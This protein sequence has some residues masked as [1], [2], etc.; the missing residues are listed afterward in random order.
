MSTGRD[1]RSFDEFR[2]I[3]SAL[4]GPDGCPWDKE[5]THESLKRFLL[6]ECYETLEALDEGAPARLC[7]ELGDVLLQILLHAQIAAEA[8][9]FSMDDVIEGIALKLI[10]RHPHVFG[11][12]KVGSAADVVQNWEAL[13]R[14]ERGEG[15]SLLASV[16]PSMP[17]LAY[18]QA[19][20]R[21]AAQAGFDW[22]DISGV[23]DKVKEELEELKAATDEKKRLHEFGDVLFA[24]VNAGRWLGVDCEEALRLSNARF[25][26]RFRYIEEAA[27]ARGVSVRDL[28]FEDLNTLWE[29]AKTELRS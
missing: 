17:A 27:A 15:E 11:D 5:Q 16:P 26:H 24:V 6:E 28:S 22:K 8:G 3:I 29:E 13:K 19:I 7:E 14:H 25:Y 1:L 4:R 21:R 9:E 20:Q 18:S 12:V 2:R 23:L 10:R